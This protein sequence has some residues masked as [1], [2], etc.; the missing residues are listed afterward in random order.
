MKFCKTGKI[1]GRKK[2]EK[3]N[4]KIVTIVSQK[5]KT[6]Y[7]YTIPSSDPGFHLNHKLSSIFPESC[8]L[9]ILGVLLGI[10]LFFSDID[11]YS[12]QSDTFFLY[13]LPPIILDSGY[14]MPYRAFFDNLGAILLFAIVGTIF[15]TLTIGLSV[16]ACSAAGLGLFALPI[17][18]E[19]L[20]IS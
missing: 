18:V 7:Y 9:I 12:L 13:L 6:D 16:W 5:K 20:C 11:G 14:F 15:N 1:I 10:I 2:C 8:L 3:K 19:L 4:G 17:K